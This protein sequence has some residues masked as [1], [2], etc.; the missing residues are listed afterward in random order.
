MGS[1]GNTIL[2]RQRPMLK[3]R[4]DFLDDVFHTHVIA[5]DVVHLQERKPASACGVRGHRQPQ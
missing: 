1:V 3:L 4:D 5:D 2:G